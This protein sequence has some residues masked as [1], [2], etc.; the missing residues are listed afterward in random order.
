ML[1]DI[2]H[3]REATVHFTLLESGERR[4]KRDVCSVCFPPTLSEK[5]K[6]EMMQTLLAEKR[7]QPPGQ[8]QSDA[9]A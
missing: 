3:G 2:C 6:N 9:A 4:T 8:R 1:C 5:E 7:N